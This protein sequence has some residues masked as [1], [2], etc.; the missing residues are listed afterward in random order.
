MRGGGLDRF[1][2]CH[3][4]CSMYPTATPDETRCCRRAF[5]PPTHTH[6]QHYAHA[7]TRRKN[8]TTPARNLTCTG[9]RPSEGNGDRRTA[10]AKVDRRKIVPHG[11]RR[12]SDGGVA[13]L[14]KLPARPK[15]CGKQQAGAQQKRA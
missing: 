13:A 3:N 6:T 14:P 8:A 2:V 15:P 12:V 4:C 10:G 9:V 11:S 5:A 7:A 1:D